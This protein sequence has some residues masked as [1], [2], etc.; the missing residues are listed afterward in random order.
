MSS[1]DF[2]LYNYLFTKAKKT[3]W[4]SRDFHLENIST[5]FEITPDGKSLAVGDV[6]GHLIVLQISEENSVL[7][8]N[9]E[10]SRHNSKITDIS[11][12]PTT[13]LIATCSSENIIELSSF[14]AVE[15]KIGDRS[16]KVRM[17]GPVR[18]VTFMEDLATHSNILF[19]AIEKQICITD[20]C[21]GLTFRDL[22]GH[23]GTVT[24]FCTW[25]GCMV[26][27]SSTDKTVRL[28]DMRVR[29]AV[30]VF[31]PLPKPAPVGS[32][33][34]QVDSSGRILFRGDGIG[35][36]HMF[37][38]SSTKK[39]SSKRYFDGPVL[40]IRIPNTK[41]Y[42]VAASK[43]SISIGDFREISQSQISCKIANSVAK[44]LVIRW[45]PSLAVF[46]TLDVEKALTQ[47]ELQLEGSDDV[48]LDS[49]LSTT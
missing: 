19:S 30:R 16:M 13:D 41:R 5:C 31:D 10:V 26:A 11:F 36:V 4:S 21:S 34:F 49:S 48:S 24:A 38:T 32:T 33:T 40:C 29:E 3:R 44:T 47:W 23:T 37:D 15:S 1:P 18:A 12:N 43:S 35:T 27:S 14:N 7:G 9:D 46:T 8:I 2:S 17:S 39:I 45:H 20:C 25:G 6:D 22:K 28:W 42:V